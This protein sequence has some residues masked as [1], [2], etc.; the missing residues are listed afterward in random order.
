MTLLQTTFIAAGSMAVLVAS[1]LIGLLLMP[2]DYL[3]VDDVPQTPSRYQYVKRLAWG[4]IFLILGLIMLVTP[5][6]GLL[7]CA[8]GFALLKNQHPRET[9]AHVV[10]KYNLTPKINKIR[11]FFNR[12]PL[13]HPNVQA[14]KPP[15]PSY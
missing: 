9:I 1:L 6:P 14:T 8:I 2:S 15:P 11:V 12:E 5:G 7:F 13:T 10:K 3:T 4:A